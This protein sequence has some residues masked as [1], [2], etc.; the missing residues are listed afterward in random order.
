MSLSSKSIAAAVFFSLLSHAQVNILTA[1]GD[2]D[3]SNSNLMETQLSPATVN[4]STFGKLGTWPVDGQVYAQPLF[5]SG[6][7]IAGGLHNV[8]FVSTMHNSVYAFDAD[9]VSLVSVLWQV[10]L[11]KSVSAALLFGQ[12]GDIQNEVG[13]LSTGV[14]DLQRSVIYV[15]ADL[16]EDGSPVF[17]LHA[18]DLATGAERL[19]GPMKMTASVT[20]SG[21]AALADGTIPF[22]PLQHI[23]RPG[24]L[25]ANNAIYVGF[26]SHGD[27]FPYHGWILSYDATDLSHR[28]GVYVSTPNGNGGAFWQSGRG[29]AADLQGNV[30]AITGNGD[31]DAV[32]NFSESFVKVSAQLSS[33]LDWFAPSDWQSMS[34]NDFDISAG[35]A[36]IAGTHTIIGADKIGDLYVINGD[37]MNQPNSASIIAAS[38]ASIFN[39]AVWSRGGNASVYTQGGGEPVKCFQVTGS[40][41][42]PDPVSTGVTSIE[43]SRISMTLSANGGLDGSG[44]LW[45]TTGDYNDGTPGTLHAYDASNLA[46]ELW[47][48]DMNPVRDQMPQVTKFVA[49]TVAN[50]KVYVPSTSNMVTVYGLYSPP[51][52]SGATPAITTVAHAASYSQDAVA[53][54]EMVAIFGSSLGPLV[55][56]GLLLDNSGSVA[57]T[58]AGTQVLFDGIASPMVFAGDGQVNAIV[59]F[60]VA[61]NTT[62]VQV[63]YQGLASAPFPMSVAPAVIGIFSADASGVG[64]AVMLNQDGS[65]NS[66]TN[67][68]APGSVV[69]LWATGA[70]QLSPAGVDG[71]VV[72][73][74]DQQRPVLTVTAQIGGQ[75]ADVV[76]AGGSPGLVEGVIQVNLRIPAASPTGDAVP[77]ALI[78][79]NSTSQP[80]ITLAIQPR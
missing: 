32:R 57:T 36:L 20:G 67:P 28:L 11:G 1:N 18:L 52:A 38:A 79:G 34:D 13:I 71:A 27:Q 12:Y 65:L 44:I 75:V 15:V 47:N 43:Y 23:Q 61:A 53:P 63:Q 39:F 22:D 62:Q 70:G 7:S 8:V 2:N 26:G 50:G 64:Q 46:N 41:V 51:S 30:Y 29:L 17:Y 45:E 42:S 77:L 68:A 59:P 78:V 16:F 69:T 76:Y 40:Q 35:P 6:L 48:S 55:P 31:Y 4:S 24:L 60:G 21:S 56:A 25:L 54:G 33:T 5:V 80:N 58:L 10:N 72:A 14:I 49:P 73:A 37:G 3:R 66:P 74:G 9:A 19:N